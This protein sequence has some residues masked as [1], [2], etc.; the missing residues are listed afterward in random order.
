MRFFFEREQQPH[1]KQN[2]AFV[3]NDIE[4][5]KKTS[6]IVRFSC[7]STDVWI[8]GPSETRNS[9]AV[10]KFI[11]FKMNCGKALIHFG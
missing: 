11:K 5:L 7:D 1:T 10:Q 4:M 8:I 3:E 2:D 6:Q 9:S